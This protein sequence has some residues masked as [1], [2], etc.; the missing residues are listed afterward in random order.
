MAFEMGTS[1]TKTSTF[2]LKLNLRL[3]HVQSCIL[4]INMSNKSKWSQ[5]STD[6]S[7]LLTS[8]QPG[9]KPGASAIPKLDHGPTS[10][11]QWCNPKEMGWQ[12]HVWGILHHPELEDVRREVQSCSRTCCCGFCW[13]FRGETCCSYPTIDQPCSKRK[14]SVVGSKVRNIRQW[15]LQIPWRVRDVRGLCID[16][17]GFQTNFIKRNS[18]LNWHVCV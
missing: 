4:E 6:Q 7:E 9:V 12:P 2:V 16:M 10:E 14:D 3:Y 18:N 13:V 1:T 15:E 8:Y 11:L 17:Q 5:S